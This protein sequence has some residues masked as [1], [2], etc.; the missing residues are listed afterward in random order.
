MLNFGKISKT[1]ES[2][3]FVLEGVLPR[4]RSLVDAWEIEQ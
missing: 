1:T 2:M 3:G 4:Q